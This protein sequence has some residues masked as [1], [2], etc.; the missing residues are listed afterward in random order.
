MI[1]MAR[2]EDIPAI[3]EIYAP[4]VWNTTFTFEY[5]IPTVAEFSARFADI[6][7][8]FPWLVWEENGKVLGYAYASAPFTRAAYQWCAEPSIYLSEEIQG[9]GIGRKLYLTLE[10]LLKQQGY[11]VLYALI[12]QENLPSLAFHEKLGYTP[13]AQLP[14]CGWK[15][16]RW[17]GVVWM[18]KRQNFV[19]SPSN[20]PIPIGDIVNSDQKL[21]DILAILSLP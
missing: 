6:S 3:L 5:T 13:I 1:R 11:R 20:A 16:D 21:A 19:D 9:K 10:E 17:L 7:K 4:Y 18:E 15:F 8:Q 12:T 14:D 2:A